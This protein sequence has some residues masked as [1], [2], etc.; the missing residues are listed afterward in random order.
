MLARFHALDRLRALAVVSMVQ[1]H[2]FSALLAPDAI[3]PPVMQ[4]HGLVHGL[5]APA[6]LFGAGL[7][8]GLAT[9]PSYERHRRGGAVLAARL[10]RYGGLVLLGYLLQVPGASLLSALALRGEQLTPLFRVGPLHLIALCMTLCQLGALVLRSARSHAWAAL[11][12]GL[13]VMASAPA[14]WSG[15]LGRSVGLPFG[16]W[17]DGSWGSQFPV[18]PWASFAFFGVAAAACVVRPARSELASTSERSPSRAGRTRRLWLLS[19]LGLAAIAYGLFRLDVKLSSATWFWYSSPVYVLFR[20]GLVMALLGSLHA[21]R[22]SHAPHEPAGWSAL[23]ARH[24]LFAYVVHLLLLYGTPF[25]PSLARHFGQR[26][27]ALQTAAIFGAVIA[28]TM[29]AIHAW[30]ALVRKGALAHGWVRV[31]LTALGVLVL[32]R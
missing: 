7:A 11:A 1:G 24:S 28:F 15:E 19:G 14:V 9:Y 2:T 17:L 4:V 20:L 16:A 31:A 5:T 18:F 23:F 27:D 22:V 21:R 30:S 29:L 3:P 6:F 12:L 10:R 25:T 13:V 8:F 32:A 26:L